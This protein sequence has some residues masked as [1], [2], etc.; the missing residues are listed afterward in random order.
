MR[1]FQVVEFGAPLEPRVLADPESGARGV[2]V[3]VASCGLCHTDA[4]LQRGHLSLGGD[5][6]LPVGMLGIQL[7]A[8]LGH[9]IYGHIAAFGQESGLTPADIGRAVIVYPWIGCGH[10]EACLA[11]RD[12]ECTTPENLGL[13]RPGGHG[14]KVVVRDPKFL[15]DAEGLDPHHAGIFACSGLTSYAALNKII[16]R[17]GP[18]GIIGMGGLGLMALAIAKGTGFGQVAAVD[19]DQAKLTLATQS[20][21]ADFSFDSR[22][23]DVGDQIQQATGGLVGVVDF[24]GSEQTSSLALSVLRTGGTYVNVGL[25]GGLLQVPLAVLAP[26]QLVLRGSYVGTPQEL[27]ELID[28]AR[29]GKIKPIPIQNEPI[30]R[31]NDG[32]DRLRAGKVTGRI[33]H[34]HH[35]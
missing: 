24:V 9:E 21:G 13:Q 20:Y 31:I 28:H 4:H 34:A 19:I 17:D 27:H 23:K 15:V 16:R 10:C 30:E 25:F 12:N 1:A 26:R 3:D 6:K 8:T 14:E 5:Q 2:V 22:A 11:G 29:T 33:V 18:I 35:T 32:L 7:P